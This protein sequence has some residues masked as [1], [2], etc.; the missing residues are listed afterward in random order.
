MRLSY[1]IAALALT[2]AAPSL[3]AGFTISLD[4]NTGYYSGNGGEFT[5]TPQGPF[6]AYLAYYDSD[7]KYPATGP[8]TGFQT[9]CIEGSETV[10]IPG[11]YNVQLNNSAIQGTVGPGGDPI[12]KGTAYLYSEFAN[13]TL[14]GYTYTP[15]TAR[16]ASAAAL[17]QAIWYLEGEA[18]GVANSFVTLASTIPN[19]TDPN[20]DGVS[21]AY[22]VMAMN[23]STPNGRNQDLLVVVPEPSTYLAAGLLGLPLL[24]VLRAGRQARK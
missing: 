5:A 8:Q 3:Q 20:F 2:L 15:G 22:P 6:Q 21:R 14:A 24:L 16:E 9:F 19:Y 18:G 23:L 11:T 4:R 17:Q 1:T 7:A 12:K 10:G 13:G